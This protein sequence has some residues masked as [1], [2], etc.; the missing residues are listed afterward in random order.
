M[1]KLLLLFMMSMASAQSYRFVYEYKMKPDAAK[2][3]SVITDYM[4]LDTDGKK[5]YFYNSVKYQRDSTYAVTGDFKDLFQAKSYD[6][7]LSYIIEK[8]YAKKKISFYDNFKTVNILIPETESPQWKIEKEFA[9]INDMN[10]QKATADYKGRT[11]EAWFSKEYPLN[12]G[13][14]KFSGLPGLII[15]LKDTGTDHVFNLIQIKK[16]NALPVIL[17]KSPKQITFAEYKKAMANYSFTNEDIEGMDVSKQDSRVSIR[18]KDGYVARFGADEMK[19][20]QK[21]DEE[22][23]RRLKR[24]DNFIERK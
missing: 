24:T 8:D 12:D 1:Y 5:S 19:K 16:I 13:P 4:N 10:C 14:Y 18:L 15:T 7:N 9:K 11:W 20:V 22:I 23:T 21:L 17:P 3:D 6:Q 2:K